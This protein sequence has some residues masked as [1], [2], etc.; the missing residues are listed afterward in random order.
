M[1]IPQAE[2]LAGYA[3]NGLLALEGETVVGEVAVR[4]ISGMHGLRRLKD[5]IAA[6]KRRDQRRRAESADSMGP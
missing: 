4:L 2:A 3:E 1:T 5:A 6:A